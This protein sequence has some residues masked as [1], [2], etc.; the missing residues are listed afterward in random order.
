MINPNAMDSPYFNVPVIG[1]TTDGSTVWYTGRAGQASMSTDAREA[2]VYATVE[3]ARHRAALLNRMTPLHGVS[4]VACVGDQRNEVL[5]ALINCPRCHSTAYGQESDGRM[6][7][8]DCKLGIDRD[9][10]REYAIG[11]AHACGYRD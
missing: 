10:N 9:N 1:R 2:F 11:Y 4:F 6:T 7:C 5:S 8:M 3:E